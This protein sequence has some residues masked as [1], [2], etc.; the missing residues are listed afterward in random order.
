MQISHAWRMK[1]VAAQIARQ[2]PRID[3]LINN[4]GALFAVRQ[5]TEDGLECTFALNHMAYFVVTEGLRKRLVASA[6]ARIVSTASDAHHGTILDFDDL[7]WDS[8]G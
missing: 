8:P 5:V 6:P 4:A 2:E 1:R 7:H 3:V